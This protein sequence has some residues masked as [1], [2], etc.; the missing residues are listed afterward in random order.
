MNYFQQNVE[1]VKNY[2]NFKTPLTAKT[3]P[4][5]KFFLSHGVKLLL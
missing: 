5:I 1:F 3:W 2:E 4:P